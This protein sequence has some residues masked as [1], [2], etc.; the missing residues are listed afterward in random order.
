[1]TKFG[2]WDAGQNNKH[3]FQILSVFVFGGPGV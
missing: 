3:Q 2:K 1:M